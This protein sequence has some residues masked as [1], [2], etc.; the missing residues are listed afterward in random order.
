MESVER[1]CKKYHIDHIV[2][3]EPILKIRPKNSKRSKEAVERLG[4]L[5][6]LEKENA[7]GYLDRYDKICIVDS[8][9]YIRDSAPNIFDQIDMNTAFAGVMEK[10]LPC[11]Q[12]YLKKIAAYSRGQYARLNDVNWNSGNW[13]IAFYNM[14]LMLFTKK[15]SEYLRGQTPEQFIRRPE[16]ERF[17]NGEGNWR[18]S[19]DQTLLNYWIQKS[20]MPQKH[21]DWRWNALFKGVQDGSLPDAHFVHFFLAN[22]L[23]KRGAEIPQLIKDLDNG[24]LQSIAQLKSHR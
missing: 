22:V 18:W 13:G 11:T 2:Q 1:Y 14:G 8:D 24:N 3:R 9:I 7:F 16:F 17:I 4:Y 5:P 10:D 15:M 6:I 20:G 12:T 19:T 23:P 21:L